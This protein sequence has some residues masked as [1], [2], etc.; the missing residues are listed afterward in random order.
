MKKETEIFLEKIKNN[1]FSGSNIELRPL[2]DYILNI[3]NF[4]HEDLEFKLLFDWHFS[5]KGKILRDKEINQLFRF[6]FEIVS[7][8]CSYFKLDYQLLQLFIFHTMYNLNSKTLLEIGGSLPEELVCD[9]FGVSD[10]INTES[11][12]YIAADGNKSYSSKHS[13]SQKLT[14]KTLY[15]NAEELCK[16]LKSDNIERIFS[17]ACFEHIYNL[18]LALK[19]CYS[20]TTNNGILYSFFSPIYSYLTDGHHGVIPS[21]NKFERTPWGLHLLK[22]SDQR[23]FLEEKGISDPSEI[24]QILGSI[25]FNRIP[26]RLLYE[27]YVR[28]LTESD[29]YVINLDEV[30]PNYN[31]HKIHP[32]E[33]AAV[34]KSNPMVNNLSTQGFR[35]ILVKITDV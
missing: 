23:I 8:L 25:N 1:I 3:H 16:E 31:I 11:P 22:S 14:K 13:S 29:Y 26:N 28:I 7:R 30:A 6:Q 34:R 20:I 33:V 4:Y 2:N 15:I 9:I 17:V 35:V 5:P 12:D 27:D 24:Q 32:K 21:H 18:E 19:Q 10:Y